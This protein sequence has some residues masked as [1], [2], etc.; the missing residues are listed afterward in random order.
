MCQFSVK[1]SRVEF[2]GCENFSC[3]ISGMNVFLQVT[4]E[5]SC[6]SGVKR[7]IN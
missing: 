6:G 2:T 5:A 7:L 4:D 1:K 3:H